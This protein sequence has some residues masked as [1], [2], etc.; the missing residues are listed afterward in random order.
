VVTSPPPVVDL[1]QLALFLDF[2]G[3]LV[4]IADHPDS[5]T[6]DEGTRANLAALAGQLEGALAIVTGRAIDDVLEHLAPLALPVAGV[7][8]LV[9]RTAAGAMDD[10]TPPAHVIEGL[11]RQLGNALDLD[12]GVLLEIKPGAIAV[13]FRACPDLGAACIAAAEDAVA[14][15]PGFV[16]SHGKMVVEAR[17]SAS[18]KGRAIMAF[19][20]E[21]PFAGRHPVFIGDDITD[22]DGFR[23]V[24][25]AG[26]IS[27]KIGGGETLARHRLDST[28]A[29][30]D[31]LGTLAQAQRS[32]KT[33]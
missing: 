26:G 17:S 11:R 14:A 30:L 31:W 29:C 6:L 22:E 20:N 4:E 18:D 21:P 5:I 1:R 27:I 8:G 10:M 3:T 2:D 25:D 33:R 28:R 23:A 9:R 19:L 32:E 16:I 13:H 12:K 7:H 24:N 15:T